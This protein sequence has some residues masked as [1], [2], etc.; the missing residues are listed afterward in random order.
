ME[1]PRVFCI[2]FQIY[3]NANGQCPGFGEYVIPQLQT[4]ALLWFC[5][6]LII[7]R[8]LV[9]L[10]NIG[11]NFWQVFSFQLSFFTI[12]NNFFFLDNYFSIV[13]TIN[14]IPLKFLEWS[15][16]IT[17]LW[18]F[19]STMWS[20]FSL[21]RVR[22][23]S[24]LTILNFSKRGADRRDGILMVLL[25]LVAETKKNLITLYK[26]NLLSD[27]LKTFF[28]VKKRLKIQNKLLRKCPNVA[29]VSALKVFRWYY[30]KN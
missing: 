24:L 28:L 10:D 23:W 8:A 12:S 6:L 18:W 27:A 30:S 17:D 13:T 25:L 11:C 29:K 2:Y 16:A 15:T 20:K 14:E 9:H 26:L 7:L 3:C 4:C 21:F 22:P 1:P 5:L 19:R